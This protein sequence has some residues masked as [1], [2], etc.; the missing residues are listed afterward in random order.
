MNQF[1]FVKF[2]HLLQQQFYGSRYWIFK[3]QLGSHHFFC[4]K[5]VNGVLKCEARLQWLQNGTQSE[6]TEQC[7]STTRQYTL[8]TGCRDQ[9][10]RCFGRLVNWMN[11]VFCHNK[12]TFQ[13]PELCYWQ[14]PL[15]TELHVF[16]IKTLGLCMDLWQ[17]TR[18]Q[19]FKFNIYGQ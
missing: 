7:S 10:N 3:E 8:L 6:Q 2:A 4:Y 12:L 5:P 11:C 13:K 1:W 19:L 9:L 15:M 17:A 16:I 14:F 18:L